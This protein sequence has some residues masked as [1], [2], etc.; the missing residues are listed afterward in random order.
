M[1]KTKIISKIGPD[2]RSFTILITRWILWD[3][4]FT[5]FASLGI[6][7]KLQSKLEDRLNTVWMWLDHDLSVRRTWEA[8]VLFLRLTITFFRV[9]GKM[10]LKPNNWQRQSIRI[11]HYSFII[12]W[13]SAAMQNAI[14]QRLHIKLWHV[15]SRNWPY[16]EK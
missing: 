1:S 12:I 3:A 13:I 11:L 10:L 4:I 14:I 8:T 5:S 9:I 16:N 7:T 15:K 6:F 2:F